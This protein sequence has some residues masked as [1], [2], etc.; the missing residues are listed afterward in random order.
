[1]SWR[2]ENSVRLNCSHRE[3]VRFLSL[4]LHEKFGLGTPFMD[5]HFRRRQSSLGSTRMLELLTSRNL[6]Q[7]C[8]GEGSPRNRSLFYIYFANGHL[9]FQF[10]ACRDSLFDYPRKIRSFPLRSPNVICLTHNFCQ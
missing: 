10:P 7:I 5:V 2:F 1:M 8:G 9:Y 3:E 4:L 6:Y